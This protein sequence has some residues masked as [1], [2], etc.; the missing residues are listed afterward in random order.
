MR[1]AAAVFAVACAGALAGCEFLGLDM[2]PA[3]LQNLEASHDLRRAL[4]SQGYSITRAIKIERM[5]ASNGKE[6]VFVLFEDG[7]GRKLSILDGNLERVVGTRS[8]SYLGTLMLADGIGNIICGQLRFDAAT[9]TFSQ[10]FGDFD[11]LGDG[12]AG[13]WDPALNNSYVV[14]SPN[15]IQLERKSF[16]AGFGAGGISSG[17][18]NLFPIAPTESFSLTDLLY[19][20]AATPFYLL[21]TASGQGE[22]L[23]LMRFPSVSAFH[24]A[25]VTSPVQNGQDL[26]YRIYSRPQDR[27]AWLTEAGVVLFESDRES[28]LVRYA[29]DS[30]LELDSKTVEGE[31]MSGISFDPSGEFWYYYD[32]RTG[33]LMKLRTWWK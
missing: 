25:I 24:T 3:E 1:L 17:A 20:G 12:R 26:G 11:L 19:T 4:A 9:E 23:F 21:F 15:P 14:F 18:Q 22:N 16:S 8:D 31:W 5:V 28:R 32:G 13:F 27:R 30:G 2:F 7:F 29:L 33:R 6:F 10:T